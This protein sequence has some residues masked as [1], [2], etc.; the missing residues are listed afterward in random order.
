MSLTI[1]LAAIVLVAAMAFAVAY[2]RAKALRGN[3]RLHSLPV[4]HGLHAAL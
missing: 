3:G 4:Y 1:A 2:R